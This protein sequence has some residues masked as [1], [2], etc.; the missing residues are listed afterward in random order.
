MSFQDLI[1]TH[2]NKGYNI[3]AQ[4]LGASFA[5]YRPLSTG[6]VIAPITLN[7]TVNFAFDIDAAFSHK[8]PNAYGHPTYYALLDLT[9]IQEGDYLTDETGDTFYVALMEPL[10]PALCV[11]CNRTLTVYRP[12]DPTPGPSY[13]G[14]NVTSLGTA[15]VNQW[16]CSLI[17]GPKGER[18]ESGLPADVRA[19]WH[20]ILL[21]EYPGVTIRTGDIL[22]FGSALRGVGLRTECPRLETNR[23]VRGDIMWPTYPMWKMP[24]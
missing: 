11:R 2:V 9:T 19:P 6:P 23:R 18:T 3:A 4:K 16:P 13:Y 15:V 17:I 14:G 24:S 20:S 7:Q 10:R 21:P 5:L 8:A 22:R 12:T 1:Q